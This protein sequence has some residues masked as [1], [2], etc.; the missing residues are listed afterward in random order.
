MFK[1]QCKKPKKRISIIIIS[2]IIELV[3]EWVG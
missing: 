3:G 1:T 2:I